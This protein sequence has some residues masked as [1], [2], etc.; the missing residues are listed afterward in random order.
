MAK[1]K[2]IEIDRKKHN[3]RGLCATSGAEGTLVPDQGKG[4]ALAQEIFRDGMG[5]CGGTRRSYPSMKAAY[6]AGV[7]R[8]SPANTGRRWGALFLAMFL[9]ANVHAAKPEKIFPP[10]G[11]PP[12]R[13]FVG[14]KLKFKVTY[15]GITVGEAESVVKEIVAVNGR[16][17]YHIEIN[18]RS[19]PVLDWIYKVRDTH[20]SYVDVQNLCS[21][22][23]EK[24]VHEGRYWTDEVMEYDQAEHLGRFFSK[25]DNSR[26]EMFIPKNVQ[27][28]I[29]CGYYYRTLD[30][31]PGTKASIPVNADEKNWDLEVLAHGTKEMTIGGIGVFEAVEVEP[32][33]LFE[34]FFVR[35]G[36]VR[37]WMSLDD[38]RV[39]LV[40]KVKIPVLGDVTATLIEYQPGVAEEHRP[41]GV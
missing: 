35:R 25:K 2:V 17:A 7:R 6:P 16:D 9:S 15:A 28:Q 14:E 8:S 31:K 11:K 32:V 22:R 1:R 30:V 33:I 29:S 4:A 39:P 21:L 3:G 38:R 26:K 19:K 18:I 36:K 41:I 37:G 27:D 40:L 13:F 10:S 23:Y 34:G 20:H 5:A 24:T 12:A